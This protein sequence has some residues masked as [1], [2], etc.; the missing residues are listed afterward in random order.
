MG[1][2]NRTRLGSV[3]SVVLAV[4]VPI[5]FA[6][7]CPSVRV[8]W[9]YPRTRLDSFGDVRSARNLRGTVY[10][11]LAVGRRILRSG[12]GLQSLEDG[13]CPGACLAGGGQVSFDERGNGCAFGEQH[14]LVGDEVGVL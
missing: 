6:G 5:D 10:G 4:L 1:T 7:R 14:P 2:G 9:P 3:F 8:P 13:V 12:G 11:R